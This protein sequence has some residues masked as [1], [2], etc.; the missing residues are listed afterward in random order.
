[1]WSADNGT[2]IFLGWSEICVYSYLQFQWNPSNVIYET[3]NRPWDNEQRS[4]LQ[5]SSSLYFNPP[6]QKHWRQT[7]PCCCCGVIVVTFERSLGIFPTAQT[8]ALRVIELLLLHQVWVGLCC[9]GVA[10]TSLLLSKAFFVP[11]FTEISAEVSSEVNC[12][13]SPWSGSSQYIFLC[14][15]ALG[16]TTSEF[17]LF[18]SGRVKDGDKPL[19]GEVM[20]S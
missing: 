8:R 5:Q 1:M 4:S 16:L 14:C 17:Y 15:R 3:L 12:G 7:E 2:I 10:E 20:S 13:F 19:S 11:D 6:H 18:W 9:V